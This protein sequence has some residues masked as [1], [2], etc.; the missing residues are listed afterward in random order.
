MIVLC[1]CFNRRLVPG[2]GMCILF[3]C[4]YGLLM[5]CPSN[6]QFKGEEGVH[7]KT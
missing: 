6:P 3:K 7:F 5:N 4:Y 2:F 1:I